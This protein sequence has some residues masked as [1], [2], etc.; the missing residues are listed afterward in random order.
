MVKIGNQIKTLRKKYGMTQIEL[1]QKAGI[2]VNSL[3]L[4][5]ADKRLPRS[6][7]ACKLADALQVSVDE[8]IGYMSTGR[9][10]QYARKFVN[11]SV[12]Q[13][14]EK[15]GVVPDIITNFETGHLVPSIEE[16]KSLSIALGVSPAFL[17]GAG[18]INENGEEEIDL[19]EVS[20]EIAKKMNVSPSIVEEVR[21]KLGGAASTVEEF[22]KI[23]AAVKIKQA[24]VQSEEEDLKNYL[25]LIEVGLQKLNSAGQHRVADFAVNLAEDLAKIPE[26][27][28]SPDKK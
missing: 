1:A 20:W 26:Y 4:Y 27:Q 16:I 23:V 24:E 25:G 14:A 9:R 6:D 8:L 5:E 19:Y 17:I 3:R 11:I 21:N 10:I 18:D 28:R 13:L 2:A 22:D 12:E 7:A 15:I